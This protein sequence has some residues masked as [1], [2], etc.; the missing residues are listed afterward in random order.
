MESDDSF[1]SAG[2]TDSDLE[3]LRQEFEECAKLFG[4]NEPERRERLTAEATKLLE[5]IE[6]IE[7]AKYNTPQKLKPKI[8]SSIAGTPLGQVFN[9]NTSKPPEVV[10][11]PISWSTRKGDDEQDVTEDEEEAAELSADFDTSPAHDIEEDHEYAPIKS[12]RGKKKMIIESSSEECLSGDD[13]KLNEKEYTLST[14]ANRDSLYNDKIQPGKL[15]LNSSASENEGEEHN[16]SKQLN[17]EMESKEENIESNTTQF[18][19]TPRKLKR[20]IESSS[21]EEQEADPNKIT[22][23]PA[24]KSEIAAKSHVIVISD[25]S[26]EENDDD[27]TN[28]QLSRR[29]TGLRRT[30]C[31]SPIMI[32]SAG[33]SGTEE[34]EPEGEDV[35]S[36]DNNLLSEEDENLDEYEED[37]F[38]VHT[39]EE[40][41]NNDDKDYEVTVVS[42]DDS[43]DGLCDDIAD[44]RLSP[45]SPPPSRKRGPRKPFTPRNSNDQALPYVTPKPKRITENFARI[46]DK[47]AQ[48]W[49]TEFNRRVFHDKLPS[50]HVGKMQSQDENILELTWSKTLNTT[51]GTTK[52]MRRPGRS[53][54]AS[55][56]LSTKVV[57]TRV[58]LKSTLAHE[59]CHAAAWLLNNNSKPP[60]GPIF[61]KWGMLV[62]AKYPDL[63]VETCHTYDINYKFKYQ[64][65]TCRKIYGRHSKSIDVTKKACG[66]CSGKLKLM[67]RLLSDGTPAKMR[68]P[69]RWQMF[70][71]AN[72]KTA[73]RQHPEMTHG[74]VMSLLSEQ[75]KSQGV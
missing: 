7:P 11:T 42:S 33:E 4:W 58:K 63:S 72:L 19:K 30:P 55:I 71:K 21:E 26:D 12:V 35:G 2:D 23:S 41:E 24:Q 62:E 43:I 68:T 50:V 70:C 59:M 51:A 49:Y 73:R 56:Q 36:D 20:V 48:E 57:D 45:S 38:I 39:S 40:E 66:I 14:D 37:S 25:S 44:T 27:S 6:N 22:T 47:L 74:Q 53:N 15:V 67:P 5:N 18:A 52:L 60:H 31:K 1:A 69:S 9:M 75:Y 61:K 34:E 65:Q 46:R 16:H 32:D 3:S 17:N 13:D 64:C 54:V 10:T 28:S 29:R 8:N